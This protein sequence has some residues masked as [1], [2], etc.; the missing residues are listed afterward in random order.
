MLSHAEIKSIYPPCKIL[1][2]SRMFLALKNCQRETRVGRCNPVGV[3]DC[4]TWG[5]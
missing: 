3:G 5:N 1:R 2:T 4:P